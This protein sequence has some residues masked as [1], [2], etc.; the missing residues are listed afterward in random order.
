MENEIQKKN[1]NFVQLYRDYMVEI[2]WLIKNNPTASQLFLFLAEHMGADNSVICSYDILMEMLD[3]S[4][5]TVSR[6][7]KFL[8]DN[9]FIDVL[10]IGKANVYVL[11][12]EVVWTTTAD[13]K[14]YAKMN[15]AVLVS[16]SENKD[17]K[18]KSNF[19]RFKRLG[20]IDN[21]KND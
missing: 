14:Q 21:N 4:K 18:Y 1:D 8:K 15:S 10:K 19:E 17:Y 6:A 3:V 12:H 2:R 16:H 7:I 13:K 5:P 11:N 9:G 20:K